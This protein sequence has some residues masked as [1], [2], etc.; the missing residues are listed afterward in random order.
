MAGVKITGDIERLKKALKELGIIEFKKANKAIGEILK[1]STVERFSTKKAPDEK[2]WQQ[3]K[4]SIAKGKTTL[5]DS[6]ILR[7][8]IKYRANAKGVVIGTNTIY[9]ATHQLGDTRTIKAKTRKGLRFNIAGQWFNKKVVKITIP[10]RPFLGISNDDMKEIE[11]TMI[12]IL[13]EAIQ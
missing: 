2:K 10:A 9:A 4:S 12:D 7:N 13:S 6:A 5:L 1:E 8:S 11:S 3:S